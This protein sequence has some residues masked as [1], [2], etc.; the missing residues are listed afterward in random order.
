MPLGR[1]LPLTTD[2][3]GFVTVCYFLAGAPD[4]NGPR[5]QTAAGWTGTTAARPRADVPRR[6]DPSANGAGDLRRR[7]A[8]TPARVRA[9][10]A[11]PRAASAT[12]R[13]LLAWL[14]ARPTDAAT[15]AAAERR[16]AIGDGSARRG[17]RRRSGRA[18]PRTRTEPAAAIGTAAGARPI[19]RAAAPRSPHGGRERRRAAAATDRAGRR[20]CGALSLHAATAARRQSAIDEQRRAAAESISAPPSGRAADDAGSGREHARAARRDLGD[21]ASADRST[22]TPRSVPTAEL[23]AASEPRPDRMTTR[24]RR[25]R[26]GRK[27]AASQCTR[28]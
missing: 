11:A 15:I 2:C 7:G 20:P 28:S 26:G 23:A 10:R 13:A 22:A 5:L 27:A 19:P 6:G 8:A 16:P 17:R 25:R 14:R 21:E 3:S 12:S 9:R 18:R 24:R 4:P 1:A